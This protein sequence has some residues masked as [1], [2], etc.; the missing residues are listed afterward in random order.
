MMRRDFGL[1]S[2]MLVRFGN[3]RRPRGKQEARNL[4]AYLGFSVVHLGETGLAG[5]GSRIRTHIFQNLPC[6]GRFR[7]S[8]DDPLAGN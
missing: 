7:R 2:G 8:K 6:Y 3:S 5:W 1:K 4:R